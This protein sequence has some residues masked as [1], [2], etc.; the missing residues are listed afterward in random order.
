MK[1]EKTTTNKSSDSTFKDSRINSRKKVKEKE[2]TSV[3]NFFG[4]LGYS[5][6]IIVMVIGGILA[7][8]VSLFLL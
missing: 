7:F 3:K 8:L 6:W 4:K 5:V 1:K 2:K